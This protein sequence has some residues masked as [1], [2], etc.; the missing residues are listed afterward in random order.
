MPKSTESLTRVGWKRLAI[1]EALNLT[2]AERRNLVCVEC[3]HASG[4]ARPLELG[5]KQ[6]I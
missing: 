6:R 1:R 5:A 3:R 2:H 4:L